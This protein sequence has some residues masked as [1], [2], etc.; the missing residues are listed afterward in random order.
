MYID[1]YFQVLAGHAAPV[2]SLAFSPLLSSS[3]L[4]S[5]SWDKTVKIWNCI[6]TSSD[7]ET[8]Q[9]GSDALQVS[10]RPDGEEVWFG[11]FIW[12]AP[13]IDTVFLGWCFGILPWIVFCPY[14]WKSV[15]FITIWN[16]CQFIDSIDDEI[17]WFGNNEVVEVLGGV[18]NL[19]FLIVNC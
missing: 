1:V 2:A 7:C 18:T 3:K 4:A 8:I 5:A 17:L 6:E 13:E 19:P 11:I 16:V 12:I 15:F 10:F 9:L 14:I